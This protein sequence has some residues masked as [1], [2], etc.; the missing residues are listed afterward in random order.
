MLSFRSVVLALA[1]TA[2]SLP[3]RR[4]VPQEHSHNSILAAVRTSLNLNNPAQIVDP[5]FALLG[6]AAAIGGAGKITD[7]DCLQQAVADQ[8]FTNAKAANDA[9]GMVNALIFRALERN[10]GK[11]GL[12]SNSCTTIT[13]TNP[14]IAAIQQHQD[15]A[16]TNAATVN[17]AI[18]LELAKQIA[19]VGGD[20]QLALKSGTFAPGNL[21]DNTGKGNTCDDANDTV[22]CIFTQNLLVPDATAAEISAAVGGVSAPSVAVQSSSATATAPA[23]A[24]ALTTAAAS[25]TATCPPPVTVTVTAGSTTSTATANVAVASVTSSSSLGSFGK[26]TVPQI[27]FG[28]GFDGRKETSFQPVDKTSYNHG[29]AQNIQIITQFICDQVQTGCGGDATAEATCL[30]AQTA[31][32][33]VTAKTGGQADA[34][35]AVFG[36]TTD[37]AAIAPVSDQGVTQAVVAAGSTPAAAAATSTAAATT[38]AVAATTTAAA[39]S[40]TTTSTA[41]SGQNLQTFTGAL[42]GVSA[43]PVTAS[44]SGFAVQ[45]N[46]NFVNLA[47]ALGRSCDVQHNQCADKANS[48]GG[49]SVGQCDTQDTQCRALIN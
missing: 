17:K 37:F 39:A 46:S 28:V 8:A 43:P 11:V 49:F 18:V 38:A 31:A 48:G 12:A 4:E 25:A 16:S 10:T 40:S 27:E 15:P 42:G 26:C 20:P 45:G 34:F 22:G 35:N 24:I 41:T 36:I 33:A 5:V 47:A 3:I 2:L 21:N 13:A 9:T 30:K 14:Q 29:S 44:G 19:S 32:L 23:V 7:P 1:V 6:N